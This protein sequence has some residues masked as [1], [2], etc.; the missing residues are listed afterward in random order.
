MSEISDFIFRMLMK[1]KESLLSQRSKIQIAIHLNLIFQVTKYLNSGEC[2]FTDQ[3]FMFKLSMTFNAPLKNITL[4]REGFGTYTIVG[5]K[6]N[7]SI[8]IDPF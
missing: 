3:K 2:F 8:W 5:E 7:E 1:S 6:Q 4:D